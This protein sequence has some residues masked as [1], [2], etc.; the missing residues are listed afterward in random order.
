[1][2]PVCH[3]ARGYMLGAPQEPQEGGLYDPGKGSH[4]KIARVTPRAIAEPGGRR[5]L[6][7]RVDTDEG[8]SGYAETEAGP[9]PQVAV[10]RLK[11]ELQRLV[12]VN[13]ARVVRL[14]EDLRRARASPASRVIAN[15]ACLDILG[16]ATEASVY[17]ILGGPT[18][19]KVRAM[20]V[21]AAGSDAELRESVLAARRDGYRA[22]S[23]PLTMP[24][25]MERGR[26]FYTDVRSTLDSLRDAAG[27]ECDFVLDCGGRPSPGEALS[28]ADRMEGFHLLWMDEPCGELSATA[29]ASISKGSVT[30]VGYGRGFTDN[31]RFQD[32]LREDGVDILRPALAVH[33]LTSIRK[34]A[35]MAETYYVA[36]APFHR[37]GPIGTAAGMQVCAALPNSFIQETPFSAKPADRRAR[38]A[39]GGWDE[40]PVDGFFPLSSRPGLGLG[41]DEGALDAYTVAR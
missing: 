19:N 15:V 24:N 3:E 8:V 34:A 40:K 36:V 20:A 41:V 22:F 30:P 10:D 32:L 16:K 9:A 38:A 23:V 35:A 27:E 25:G 12:G 29:Q 21:L 6:V 13:P 1:M 26:R 33:G 31:A 4:M 14:D 37:G 7:V 17:E 11:R 5:Y 28:I 2:L 18:R 39:I